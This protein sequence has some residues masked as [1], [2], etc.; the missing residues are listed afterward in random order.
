MPGTLHIFRRS[1]VNSVPFFQVDL[2]VDNYTYAKVVNSEAGLREF[3]VEE[4]GLDTTEMD[5]IESQLQSGS[6]TIH[7]IE[8]AE[9]EAIAMGMVKAPTDI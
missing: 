3:L 1:V 5:T 9:H 8:I 6:A 4:A 2:T 7:N